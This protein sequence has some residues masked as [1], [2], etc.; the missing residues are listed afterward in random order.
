[1]KFKYI[2]SP[3]NNKKEKKVCIDMEYELRPKITKFLLNRL[4][5][6]CEGDFSKFYFDIHFKGK[7][8]KISSKTPLKYRKKIEKDF[9]SEFNGVCC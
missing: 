7:Q 1:M 8:I 9:E 3:G 2:L 6:D 5:S 4:E